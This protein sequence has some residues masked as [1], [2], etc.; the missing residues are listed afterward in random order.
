M[1]NLHQWVQP[2]TSFI[3]FFHQSAHPEARSLAVLTMPGI[4]FLRVPLVQAHTPLTSLNEIEFKG[5]PAHGLI[6]M[7]LCRQSDHR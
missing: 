7:M 5:V 6:N 4:I 2:I 1:E 3:T